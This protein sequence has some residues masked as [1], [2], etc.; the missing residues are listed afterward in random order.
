MTARYSPDPRQSCTLLIPMT[1]LLLMTMMTSWTLCRYSQLWPCLV[2]SPATRS[3]AWFLVGCYGPPWFW[4][5]Q[6]LPCN[7]K[8]NCMVTHVT[9]FRFGPTLNAIMYHISL[10]NF[11]HS[12]CITPRP[13]SVQKNNLRNLLYVRCIREKATF[14]VC[15]KNVT[16]VTSIFLLCSIHIQQIL[17]HFFLC[18][19]VRSE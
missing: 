6:H 10:I 19:W 18:R 16:W 2:V 7:F 4:C 8:E 3:S 17:W 13:Y 11:F 9:F 1:A 5:S 15:P 14:Y 12:I